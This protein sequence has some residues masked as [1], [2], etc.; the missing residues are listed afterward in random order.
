LDKIIALEDLVSKY[1]NSRF[2]D[3]ALFHIGDTYVDI[4]RY[5]Q[6]IAAFRRIVTDYR[7][8]SS[9]VN[10]ALLKLGLIS[11]NQGN[12]TAAIGGSS[13]V[14]LQACKLGTGR[15]FTTS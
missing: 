14:D 3:D 15:R 4:G 5:D 1:P 12:T 6:A 13:R 2:A 11:Y 9:L 10:R 8:R 7:N